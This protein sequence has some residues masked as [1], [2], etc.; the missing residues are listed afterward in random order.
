MGSLNFV[1]KLNTFGK[2]V[3]PILAPH[4]L[5][6]VTVETDFAP[7]AMASGHTLP[8]FFCAALTSHLAWREVSGGSIWVSAYGR[9][10]VGGG[11]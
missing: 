1:P 2:H 11:I 3:R 4:T 10:H 6:V 7:R 9:R 5:T 8:Q